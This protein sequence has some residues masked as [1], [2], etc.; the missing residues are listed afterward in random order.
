MKKG[1]L[2]KLLRILSLILVIAFIISCIFNGI[3]YHKSLHS[4]PLYQIFIIDF[5]YYI[6]PSIILFVIS[7]YLGAK[8]WNILQ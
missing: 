2:I 1:T 3:N 7:L 5:I 8:K 6:V 4:L